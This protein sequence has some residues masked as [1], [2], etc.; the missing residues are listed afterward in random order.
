MEVGARRGAHFQLVRQL[1]LPPP[2]HGSWR[3]PMKPRLVLLFTRDRAFDQ[4]V[5]EALFAAG[6]I[7][8]IARSVADALQIVCQRGRELDFAL[9]D[10]DG[11]CRGMTL[12]SAVHTCH[13]QLPILVT[14]S[15]D[16]EHA[17]AVA[18]ANGARACLNKPLHAAKLANAIADLNATHHQLVAA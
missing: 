11:G 8:F 16:A 18:H 1:D 7:V 9:M 12:L 10:F 14:T 4:L 13:Q 6:A 17:T 2:G 5:S 15:E 3:N